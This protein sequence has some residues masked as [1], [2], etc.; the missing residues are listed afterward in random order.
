MTRS[1]EELTLCAGWANRYLVQLIAFGAF[2]YVSVRLMLH[3]RADLI[4][5]YIVLLPTLIGT[6]LT[7]YVLCTARGVSL[8]CLTSTVEYTNFI[9]LRELGKLSD[10]DQIIAGRRGPLLDCIIV[11]AGPHRAV[12]WT[13]VTNDVEQWA[14]RVAEAANRIDH[15]ISIDLGTRPS[16]NIHRPSRFGQEKVL[17]K[18]V[19]TRRGLSA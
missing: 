14:E 1:S 15:E 6:V 12:L 5:W 17:F 18:L 10:V 13:P 11:V 9:G 16:E 3:V 4:L 7:G 2:G 19:D 8:R